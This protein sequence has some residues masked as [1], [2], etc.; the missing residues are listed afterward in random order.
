MRCSIR[1]LVALACV[2]VQCTSSP[3]AAAQQQ[4]AKLT[5]GDGAEY[6]YF[7]GSV[8]VSGGFALVGVPG[9][10]SGTFSGSA[11]VFELVDGAWTKRAK[12]RAS[13]AS[14][15]DWF[16]ISVAL[17]GGTC[18]VGASHDDGGEEDT[19]SAYVFERAGDG[20]AQAAKL[21]APDAARLAYF[22][23]SVSLS[24][25]T[26]FIGAPED[27][28][29]GFRAGAVY[30]FERV[31]GA[32][33]FRAKIVA[34]DGEPGSFF[35]CAVSLSADRALVGAW[36]DDDVGYAGGAAYVFEKA[37]GVWVEVAKL[38]AHDGEA[39]DHFGHSV[40]LSGDSAL[41]GLDDFWFGDPAGAAY[42]FEEIGG[43]WIE[44]A[45]LVAPDGE[46][47]DRFGWSVGLSGNLAL[48][49]S[50]NDDA[51][52]Y[53]SGSAYLFER[54]GHSWIYAAKL[55]A[56]DGARYDEFGYALSISGDTAIVGSIGDDD[57][58]EDSGA[59]Y[60]FDLRPDCPADFNGDGAVD[61]RDVLG[62]L[63]AWGAGD[64]SADTDGN[65]VIDTRDVLAF[66]NLWSAG[67]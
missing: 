60:V 35:G 42:V 55:T 19:G 25:E 53:G 62:F 49:G 16:G 41:V 52:G 66:L 13:D 46:A 24:G 6:E 30:V 5:A 27:D 17:D 4:T 26:A 22:G 29:L 38:V 59:A 31:A 43:I 40:S 32:W 33:E 64:A 28:G 1:W 48:V 45:K 56:A 23:A 65:G 21:T 11:Y 9:A 54:D 10:D 39:E 61:T 2:G 47:G 51:L 58:G 34:S 57:H 8:A 18:L 67:C 50:N 15:D 63:S 12:L 20:W 14:I 37:G 44:T 3:L 7:G 36:A